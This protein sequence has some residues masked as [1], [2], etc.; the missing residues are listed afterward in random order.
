MHNDNDEKQKVLK[1]QNGRSLSSELQ[2]RKRD[3]SAKR[4]SEYH[5]KKPEE[6]K[7]QLKNSAC[8]SGEQINLIC[9]DESLLVLFFTLTSFCELVTLNKMDSI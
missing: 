5:P 8:V 9:K 1:E 7:V 4:K 6:K 2:H 3:L